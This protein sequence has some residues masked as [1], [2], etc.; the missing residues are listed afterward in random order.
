MVEGV[1]GWL[2]EAT[3]ACRCSLITIEQPHPSLLN[4]CHCA[5]DGYDQVEQGLNL[6]PLS[7]SHRTANQD[8]G[9]LCTI[10]HQ[11]TEC[12]STPL[13]SSASMVSESPTARGFFFE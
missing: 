8:C 3:L 9:L 1:G 7:V 11:K 10:G 6:D 5:L 13:R 2:I 4:I 12:D